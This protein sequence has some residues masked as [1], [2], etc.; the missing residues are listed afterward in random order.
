MAILPLLL[1]SVFVTLHK[2]MVRNSM[3]IHLCFDLCFEQKCK[4]YQSFFYHIF[5]LNF[6]GGKIFSIFE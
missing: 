5:F 2:N 3:L 1:Q 6:Y 4:K